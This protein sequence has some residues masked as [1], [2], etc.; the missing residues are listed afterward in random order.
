LVQP[1]E[2]NQA[3]VTLLLPTEIATTIVPLN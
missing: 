1:D 2:H 3:M